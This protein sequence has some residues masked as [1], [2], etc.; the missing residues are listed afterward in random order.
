PKIKDFELIGFPY[1]VVIG[2]KLK[3]GMVE[4]RNRKTLEKTDIKTEDIYEKILQ[5][6]RYNKAEV[7]FLKRLND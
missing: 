6:T 3:D 2:K 7:N 4:L 1:A 5:L